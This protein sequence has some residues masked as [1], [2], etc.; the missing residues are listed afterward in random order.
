MTVQ[1]CINKA[2]AIIFRQ[3]IATAG[4]SRTDEGVHAHSNFYQFDIQAT[5]DAKVLYNLNALLPHSLCIRNIFRVAREDASARFDAIERHYRYRIYH[6]KNPFLFQKA[7]LYPYPLNEAILHRCAALLLQ[8]KDFEA[9]S[10]KNTQSHTFL[11]SLTSSN[12]SRQ[13]GELHYTVSGNRFLRGMVRALVG[14]QLRAARGKISY[15]DFQNII[16]GKDCSKADFSVAG[17]GLYL[18]KIVYPQGLLLPL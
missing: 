15:S 5:L 14:T 10:K 4:A 6:Q 18:E 7:L 12:W 8:Y 3:P 17:F 1:Y 13:D 2:L 11:C 16:E 9:F